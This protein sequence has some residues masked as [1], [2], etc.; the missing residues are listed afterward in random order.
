M[1]AVDGGAAVGEVVDGDVGTAE[2][3]CGFAVEVFACG[4]LA[5]YE[6]TYAFDFGQ[7][8]FY[9]PSEAVA[10]ECGDQDFEFR[11][12]HRILLARRTESV[13]ATVASRFQS[14]RLAKIM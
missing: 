8:H 2:Q 12:D 11:R 3:W 13:A 14:L 5:A 4:V 10:A 1:V 6:V 9:Y 7:V